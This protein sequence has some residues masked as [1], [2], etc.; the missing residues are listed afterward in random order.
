METEVQW[1]F[2]DSTTPQGPLPTVFTCRN[3][4]LGSPQAWP[5]LGEVEDSP[6]TWVNGAAPA[7]MLPRACGI[8]GNV[9]DSGAKIAQ[10]GT[11]PG[12]PFGQLY[13]CLPASAVP[14]LWLRP[15]ELT[16]FVED[17]DLPVWPR[18]PGTPRD[19]TYRS[20]PPVKYSID[21]PTGFGG[22]VFTC[23]DPGNNDDSIMEFPEITLPGDFLIILVARVL[24]ANSRGPS[25]V[26]DVP[27]T[28]GWFTVRTSS[29]ARIGGATAVVSSPDLVLN[30]FSFWALGRDGTTW[31]I[32]ID[33][34]QT[35]Q[36]T[37][38]ADPWRL[39]WL[40]LHFNAFSA[41]KFWLAEAIV[42]N[43]TVPFAENVQ[44]RA[45]IQD[46]YGV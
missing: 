13:C 39:N 10:A 25:I 1:F 44:W 5:L 14:A 42:L 33:G 26:S 34:V 32:S 15:E 38:S 29:S 17:D 2:V 24:V 21:A 4:Y 45:Y 20:G 12:S 6:R 40:N 35:G 18:A 27:F 7:V 19:A 23:R 43:R 3:W 41:N 31:R 37:A 9:F 46:K 16:H 36:G 11:G 22:G 8:G 30:Q 28:D